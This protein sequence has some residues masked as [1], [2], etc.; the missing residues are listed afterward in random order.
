MWQ[1][2]ESQSLHD[3][4]NN[5]WPSTQTHLSLETYR[6]PPKTSMKP[7][8]HL[9]SHKGPVMSPWKSSPSISTNPT[10]TQSLNSNKKS[11]ISKDYWTQRKKASIKKI[12]IKSSKSNIKM[13]RP[14]KGLS[15]K[16]SLRNYFKKTG[17]WKNKFFC[18]KIICKLAEAKL[19]QF[20]LLALIQPILQSSEHNQTFQHITH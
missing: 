9:N 12:S 6:P 10:P 20:T 3:S 13:I 18:S 16:N 5:L 11:S 7:S 2:S 14:R 4:Y 17:K 19:H 1:L 15:L 8:T